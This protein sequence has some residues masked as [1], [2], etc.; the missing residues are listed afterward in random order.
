MTHTRHQAMAR[1][2]CISY[3]ARVVMVVDKVVTS[4]MFPGI[5]RNIIGY[6]LS[7]CIA[8]TILA[9]LLTLPLWL[10]ICV[11]FIF[12]E[13]GRPVLSMI[14]AGSSHTYSFSRFIWASK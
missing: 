5:A 2:V 3:S 10:L 6:P 8:V 13:L 1:S 9:S 4:T 11:I 12:M 7:R 14:M